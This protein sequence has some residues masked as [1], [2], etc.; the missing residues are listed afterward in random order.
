VTRS[1][2]ELSRERRQRAGALF[3]DQYSIEIIGAWLTDA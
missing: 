3:L 2:A 1:A